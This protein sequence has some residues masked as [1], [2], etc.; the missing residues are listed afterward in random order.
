M[1]PHFTYCVLH[2]SSVQFQGKFSF[3]QFQK[4]LGDNTIADLQAGGCYQIL[5]IRSIWSIQSIPLRSGSCKNVLTPSFTWLI[6]I[7]EKFP[8]FRQNLDHFSYS[9]LWK[10]FHQ[11]KPNCEFS[12]FHIK[13]KPTL[14]IWIFSKLLQDTQSVSSSIHRAILETSDLWHIWSAWWEDMIKTNTR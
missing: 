4:N 2:D 1:L 6:T 11:N 10:Y 7:M 13:Y 3:E 12:T 5:S 14:T 9:E 8:T